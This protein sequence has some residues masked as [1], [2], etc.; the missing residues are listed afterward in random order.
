MAP[1]RKRIART[2]IQRGRSVRRGAIGRPEFTPHSAANALVSDLERYPHAYVI[3]CLMDR[4]I[5][6]ER[7][8]EI[9]HRLA[10][11]LG[12]FEFREL[13]RLRRATLARAMREPTNLHRF[14]EIMGGVV[15]DAIRLMDSRYD[16]DASAIWSGRPSSADLVLRFLEFP[17]AGAK[18]A[19]M[20]TNL[21]VRYWSIPLAD[22]FSIDISVDVHVRRVLTRLRL[23][24][25]GASVE[26]VVYTARAMSP[27]FPGLIDAP[28]FLLGREICRPTRPRCNDC[29]L[30]R[31]C[32][33]RGRQ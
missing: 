26:Q 4:Q 13:R 23:V 32:P 2:L 14:A 5:K 12:T 9:P 8:W 6:A 22:H 11:R 21:L 25:P 19:T 17:G 16:G 1:D 28:L 24:E 15:H 29:Y 27:T 3:A 7:A 33:S 31:W 18:I 30:H 20:A 10:E